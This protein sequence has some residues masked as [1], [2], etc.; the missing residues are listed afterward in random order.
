M[1]C[2][3]DSGVDLNPDTEPILVGR[4]SVLEGTGD[5]VTGYHHGTYVA[6]VAGAAANGWGMIGAW[7]QLR[8]LS[9]R[10]LP[11]GTEHLSGDAYR[12][13]MLRC[14][15]AKTVRG[16]DIRVMEL[17]LGGRAIDRPE[18]ELAGMSDAVAYARQNG[19][20]V[21]SAAGNDAGAVNVPA[22][23]PGVVSVGAT[24]R[25]GALCAF[26]S[27]G[28]DLDLTAPGCEMDVA[29]RRPGTSAWVR[30]RA[31]RPRTRPASSSRCAP[32]GRT[33]GA[34]T[35]DQ[36]RGALDVGAA[37]RAAG[38]APCADT[39]VPAAPQPAA[40]GQTPRT[41]QPADPRVHEAPHDQACE[42]RVTESSSA[43][44][45]C[46]GPCALRCE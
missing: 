24:D 43:C 19:I 22:S 20:V 15:Q 31:W 27:R 32:T 29:M 34:Q 11:E 7:P 25:A 21:V 10:A 41:V 30:A 35:E 26:S 3:V 2:L 12:A 13:G 45:R 44:I 28:P 37:F 4:E 17:A 9:V 5:D 46:Q 33:Y 39:Y 23:V 38:L 14:V 36:V 1:L 40:T 18:S 16:V 42:G 6:M 8:V